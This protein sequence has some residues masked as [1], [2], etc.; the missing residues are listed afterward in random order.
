MR[1][2]SLEVVLTLAFQADALALAGSYPDDLQQA[3]VFKHVGSRGYFW[4]LL[5]QLFIVDE[6]DGTDFSKP[7]PVKSLIL[8]GDGPWIPNPGHSYLTYLGPDVYMLLLDCRAERKKDLVCSKLTYDRI[9]AAI[10]ALPA[11]KHLVFQLGIPIAYRASTA[12]SLSP[13]PCGES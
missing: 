5:F 2:R 12:L 11:I 7:H 8:G 13:A 9:F 10:K 1:A 4:Y 6:V 3:P